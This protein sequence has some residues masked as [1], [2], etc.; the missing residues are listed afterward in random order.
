M[1]WCRSEL[2]RKKWYCSR[3]SPLSKKA[4]A[5][6]ALRLVGAAA[7][8]TLVVSDAMHDLE[9]LADCGFHLH[10]RQEDDLLR[11]LDFLQ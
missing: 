8:T 3:V 10:V 4:H 6:S 5:D 11:T 7:S 1:Q 2:L 9:Q